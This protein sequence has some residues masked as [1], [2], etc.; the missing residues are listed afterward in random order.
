MVE[1]ALRGKNIIAT[2]MGR[3]VVKISRYEPAKE[4]KG[5]GLMEDMATISDDFD[6][7]PVDEARA[8]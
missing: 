8:S 4:D 6:E 5:L 1:K 3:P 7:W 2:R